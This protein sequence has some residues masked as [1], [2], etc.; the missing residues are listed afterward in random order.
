MLFFIHL[1]I[2]PAGS[3]LVPGVAVGCSQRWSLACGHLGQR[4]KLETDRSAL[5][6]MLFEERYEFPVYLWM[7]LR[8]FFAF[9]WIAVDVV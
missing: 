5:L 7:F 1:S 8:Q 4:V 2:L 6:L 3:M 9:A